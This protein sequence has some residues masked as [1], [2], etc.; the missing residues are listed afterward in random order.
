M[1]DGPAKESY[2]CDEN[3]EILKRTEEL[4]KKYEVTVATIA[5]A[6]IFSQDFPVIPILSGETIEQFEENVQT[7]QKRLTKE[8]LAWLTDVEA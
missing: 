5:L 7:S 2:L 4:A 6:Y 1:L 3:F 8:E